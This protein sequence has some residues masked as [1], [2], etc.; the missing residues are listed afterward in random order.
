MNKKAL[1]AAIA[2]SLAAPMAA[3]A[4]D[5]TISGHINRGIFITNTDDDTEVTVE[6]NGSSGTRIRA[7][8]S[9][10]LD[11][12]HTASINLEVGAGHSYLLRQAN[13]SFSGGFGKLTIGQAG[14]AGDGAA[15]SDKSGVF[16]I[17]MGQ[18]FAAS[19]LGDYFDSLAAGNRRETVRYDTPALGPVGLAVS[20]S[21]G[22][23]YGAK[24]TFASEM[25]GGDIQA[26]FAYGKVNNEKKEV[27]YAVWTGTG[28]LMGD[29]GS[30]P[31]ADVHPI[32]AINAEGGRTTSG[33][34]NT[35]FEN[36]GTGPVDSAYTDYQSAG[37]SP[38]QFTFS[39]EDRNIGNPGSTE[40]LNANFGMKFGSGLTWSVAWASQESDFATA[41][42][43]YIQS[44]IGYVFGNNAVAASWWDTEEMPSAGAE[45]NAIGLGFIHKMPKAG[46]DLI[47]A[48]QRYSAEDGGPSVD[49]TVAVVG[50]RVRF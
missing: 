48:A 37:S 30:A 49:E 9:G 13:V 19:G 39:T 20:A 41:E 27:A 10:K 5:F 18:D 31:L 7:T 43:A 25:M 17:G 26:Q 50:A 8:G 38:N 34:Q 46:V 44:T 12:G 42:P 47:A 35:A 15:S 4:V 22:D 1:T 21:T 16:G 40:S 45:G 2:A 33:T 36:G 23:R 6:D 14:E 32:T 11:T 24:L 29:S 28:N 3:Q